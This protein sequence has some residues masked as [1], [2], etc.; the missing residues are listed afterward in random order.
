MRRLGGEMVTCLAR[1]DL[2]TRLGL[3]RSRDGATGGQ[4][5]AD[6][7]VAACA[8]RPQGR[9]G[10]K[11][12]MSEVGADK[13]VERPE[14]PRRV[15]SGTAEGTG[16]ARQTDA[17]RRENDGDEVPMVIEGALRHDGIVSVRG[18]YR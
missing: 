7:V 16:L 2:L 10:R 18:E 15:G 3:T 6:T 14:R 17:E 11:R 13:R 1:G 4:K 12:S 8:R 9:T 5:S